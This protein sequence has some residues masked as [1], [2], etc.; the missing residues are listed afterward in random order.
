[1][2]AALVSQLRDMGVALSL[3]GD[4]LRV[5]SKP[6]VLTDAMRDLIGSH[7]FELIVAL[8]SEHVA[9]IT[10]L[11]IKHCDACNGT[12]WGAISAPDVWSCLDCRGN[13]TSEEAD[14]TICPS[15]GEHSIVT[16]ATGRVCLRSACR[17][18]KLGRKIESWPDFRGSISAPLMALRPEKPESRLQGARCPICAIE[19]YG[20]VLCT[21]LPEWRSHT[22]EAV[23]TQKEKRGKKACDPIEPKIN[24]TGRRA[25]QPY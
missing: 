18:G 22:I 6:G 8:A 10:P 11:Y 16:D 5:D 3:E 20:P 24:G 14:D 17:F 7:K 15:C 4:R 9:P 13:V 19:V 23:L 1:M 2:S 25:D 21:H 12:D